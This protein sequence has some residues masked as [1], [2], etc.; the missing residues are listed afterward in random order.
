[1]ARE[2]WDD[3]DRSGRFVA[4]DFAYNYLNSCD[5]NA[6]LFTNGDNDTFPLWYAQEV[7]GIRTDVRVMNLSYLGADWYIE[8]MHRKAYESEPVPFSL[9]ID[10]Y[11]SGNRDIVYVLDRIK[12]FSD[13]R[14][15]IDFVASDDPRTKQLPDINQKIDFIPTR[16]F[17]LPVDTAK[18]VRNG[19]VSKANASRLQPEMRWELGPERSYITKNH[20]MI[21]DLLATNNWERPLYYAITVSEDN[22]LNLDSFFQM[23][24]LAYRIVPFAS[25][26]D[27]FG[28]GGI[29]TEAMFDNMVNK[30]RWGGVENPDLYLDENVL[31][32]LGNFRSSFARLALQL[33]KENKPDSAR[34]ALDKCLEVIPDKV[35]PF[36]VYNVLL[37]EA[38]YQLGDMDKANEIVAGIKSNVY[39]EM[40]YFISLGRKYDSYL[41]YEKRIAFYTLD[42][43][44]RMATTFN[45][46][47]LKTEMEQKLQEYAGTLNIAM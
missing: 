3:H 4:R 6:I 21:L 2:N 25:Q 24:G 33:I 23:E 12:G 30:F 45:Q 37:V 35:V 29:N 38:Y 5:K 41:M 46:T 39:E 28:R 11:R 10:K 36:N 27:I 9:T 8:Q 26:G 44:R 43:L 15:V 22:Y 47:E 42:E 32:M 17:I 7:E 13:L 16:S 31:R 40:N 19:T 20:L 18:L 34:Q 1:M 14:Q